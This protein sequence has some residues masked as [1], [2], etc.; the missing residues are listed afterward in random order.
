[1]LRIFGT[2]AWAGKVWHWANIAT[3]M[4]CF[5]PAGNMEGAYW[6]LKAFVT[7]HLRFQQF[8]RFISFSCSDLKQHLLYETE[9]GSSRWLQ[10]PLSLSVKPP[11]RKW[12]TPMPDLSLRFAL[13]FDLPCFSP[14]PLHASLH[15]I[16]RFN[17]TTLLPSTGRNLDSFVW[18]VE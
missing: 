2:W 6:L 7:L 12:R 10:T 13:L 4:D 8:T 18:I 5:G 1:M 15:Q 9:F 16:L 3:V 11:I 17:F 14:A